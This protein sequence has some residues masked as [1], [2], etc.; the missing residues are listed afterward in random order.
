[1]L[2]DTS[3]MLCLFDERDFRHPKAVYNFQ[4]AK[5]L[6]TTNYILAEFVPL[7]NSRKLPRYESLNFLKDFCN[8]PR[9]EIVW[10]DES[11]HH[12]AFQLL[13]NRLDKS[14][15]LCDAV[16]F[17]VMSERKITEA[18]TTDHHFSQEGFIKLLDS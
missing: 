7:S 6:I 9:L 18:L 16:S 4:K 12:Q 8:L 17:I 14:Y 11:L 10:I 1:M 2:I 3:G 15:S 13:E 5:S